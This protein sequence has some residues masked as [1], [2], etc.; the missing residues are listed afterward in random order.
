VIDLFKGYKKAVNKNKYL[1][2]NLSILSGTI[3]I[4]FLFG[5]FFLISPIKIGYSS[6]KSDGFTLYYP[7]SHKSKSYDIYEMAKMAEED[8]R[9]FYGNIKNTKILVGLTDIDML[10]FG[11]H[12]KANGSGTVFGIVIRESKATPNIIAH[13]MSHKNLAEISDVKTSAKFPRW[14]DEGLASYI[15]K[16]DYYKTEQDLKDDLDKG[17]YR[18]DITEWKGIGG[19]F[20]WLNL[21]FIK[22]NPRLIYGQ[23]YL[24]VKYLFEKYGQEKVYNLV[25][26]ASQSNFDR[27]FIDV[28]GITVNDFH[29]EFIEYIEKLP[30]TQVPETVN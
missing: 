8:N 4:L 13:E 23:T 12:P 26:Q 5:P 21:T 30:L 28:F 2:K 1:F 9:D 14:F 20:Q 3:L 11:S 29:K 15:G 7:S 25:L 24:M 16:M 18:R 22:P 17:M 6:L 27:T 10:R 19:I